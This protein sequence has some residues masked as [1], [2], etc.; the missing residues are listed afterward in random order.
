ME[1]SS[2]IKEYGRNHRLCLATK[3]LDVMR[4]QPEQQWNLPMAGAVVYYFF[5]KVQLVILNH[6]DGAGA[7]LSEP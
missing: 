7:H 3:Y 4:Q 5:P 2:P 6:D 1:M